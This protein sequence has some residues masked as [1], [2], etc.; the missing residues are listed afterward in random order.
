MLKVAGLF[1]LMFGTLAHAYTGQTTHK[2]PKYT[3]ELQAGV[4]EPEDKDWE[5]YYG[6]KNMLEGS[7]SF[8]YRIFSVFDVGSSVSFGQDKGTGVLPLSQL[9]AG[10]VAYEILP[11]DFYV[12]LRARFT[13][14]QWVVPY[15][16]GGYTRFFYRQSIDGEGYARGSVD[17][18][19]ARAGL[20]ILLDPLDQSS[21]KTI[22]S[23]YGI[24]NSYLIFEGKIT[25]A[26]AGTPAIN[27]GGTSYRAGIMVEY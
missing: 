23:N 15:A 8:A 4:Y 17:G 25:K 26:E 1:F 18:L 16:G 21:A 6:S 13:E 24:I 14:R 19:H 12:V 7:F 11:V 20:Q 3:M 27:L 10:V 22:F 9:S 2:S 5:S